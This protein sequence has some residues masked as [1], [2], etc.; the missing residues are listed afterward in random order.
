MRLTLFMVILCVHFFLGRKERERVD[1]G[2]KGA[3]KEKR[4]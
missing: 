2:G 3:R 1:I 4:G